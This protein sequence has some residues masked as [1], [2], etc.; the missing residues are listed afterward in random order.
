MN[1]FLMLTLLM[2]DTGSRHAG[3]VQRRERR[4]ADGQQQPLD[5]GRDNS[6]SGS[7]PSGRNAAAAPARPRRRPAR[8][9]PAAGRC[10]LPGGVA[11]ALAAPLRRRP[12]TPR[13]PPQFGWRSSAGRGSLAN[14][15]FAQFNQF[16]LVILMNSIL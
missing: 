3:P 6:G 16:N 14:W 4:G 13:R 10:P 2:W 5:I 9:C 12:S 11:V 15:L 8:L 7:G 1:W